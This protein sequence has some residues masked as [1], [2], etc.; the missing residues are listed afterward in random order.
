MGTEWTARPPWL[1]VTCR[2]MPRAG[3]RRGGWV[4]SAFLALACLLG[5][6][7][8]P[9]AGAAGRAPAKVAIGEVRLSAAGGGRAALLVPVRYPIQLRGQRLELRVFLRV[10]GARGTRAWTIRTR[11]GAGPLRAPERRRRFAFVHRVDL[12]AGLTRAVEASRGR[13]RVRVQADAALDLDRDGVTEVGSW[14]ETVQRLGRGGE[15]LCASVP[16][17]RVKPG[18]T[19]AP[20]LPACGSRVRWRLAGEPE[21]GTARIRDGRLVYRSAR[22]FRGTESIELKGRSRGAPGGALE[23]PVQ[24]EV[25]RGKAPVVRALGDSVTAGF[26]YYDDG[27]PMP[28]AD[29][30]ECQ[31][32][33]KS[34]DDACSSNSAAR[35]NR[36]PSVEYA[37]DYGLSN[38]VS[39][40][41]QW[42]NAHGVSNYEN[43]A[44]SGSGPSDW[45]PGGQL[46][47]TTERI[48]AEDPD[49]VL[50]TI[51]ANPLL[52]EMLFGVDK[53]GCAIWSDIFGRY[54]ECIEEAFRGVNL[55]GNLERLYRELAGNT[56]ATI[57]LM[58]YHLSVP[59][60]A[61]LYTATQIAMMGEL[62]NREIAS[63]AAA[64]D[65]ERLRVVAPPH[66]DVGI[67]ISPVYPSTYSCSRFG[68]TVD[69][70][71]VQSTPT[72]EELSILHPLSFCKGPAQGPPWVIGGDTGIHPSAAGY[73]QMASRV[74]AP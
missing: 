55:R 72:Q 39:W 18:R 5:P 62:L 70:Q 2:R 35:S 7:S 68:F 40:A 31:P 16:Q 45:A 9:A 50:M 59:S 43:L 74:P 11:G 73:T 29:L 33:E 41:A 64:V 30:L 48:E 19:V 60:V 14:D 58:Q 32:P 3:K 28:L 57:Y 42:A 20:K 8:V 13:P 37:P 52:S 4:A 54:S 63:V 15:R 22:R 56:S 34:Y 67:D 24:I 27:S 1:P 12:G 51:G 44:V 49:F 71:S 10:P 46:H 23:A 65:P 36:G 6:A 25:E 53:M 38:N 17:L 26:G 47:P 21:H 69:G 66:F 61:L